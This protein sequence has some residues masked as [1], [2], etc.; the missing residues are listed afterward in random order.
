MTR[1]GPFGQTPLIAGMN[2]TDQPAGAGR[3]AFLYPQCGVTMPLPRLRGEWSRTR[4]VIRI[5]GR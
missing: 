1:F 3:S 2:G 5:W 4:L